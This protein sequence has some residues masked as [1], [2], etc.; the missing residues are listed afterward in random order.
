MAS[1]Y[2]LV[3]GASNAGKTSMINELTGLAYDVNNSARGC[4]FDT[5]QVPPMEKDGIRYHFLDTAGLN[6][7]DKGTVKSKDAVKNIIKLL[8]HSRTGINLLVYVIRIGTITQAEKD[9]YNMF[10]NIITDHKIPV[11]CVITGCENEEPMSRWVTSNKRFF[12]ENDMMFSDM[13]ATCFA[14]G[15]RF[16][17][18][19]KP[20]REESAKNVWKAIITHSTRTPVDFVSQSGGFSNLLR[21]VWNWF[22][23]WSGHDAWKWINEHIR[24]MLIRLGFQSNEANDIAQDF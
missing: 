17:I 21:K 8:K 22:C 4:T 23:T 13:I 19:Y 18:G 14:K 16:E 2:V 12:E 9:N 5:V 20:L 6:E 11:I 1:R 10:C 3:F 24:D 15:G 7:T